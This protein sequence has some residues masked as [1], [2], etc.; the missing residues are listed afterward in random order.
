M[1]RIQILLQQI[2]TAVYGKDVRQSIHDSIEQCYTDVTSAKT[3]A[4]DSIT[5]MI[6]KIAQCDT[7]SANANEKANLA[8]TAASNADAKA[9]LAQSAAD[10]ADASATNCDNAVAELPDRVTQVFAGLGLAMI[11]GKLCVEV[12]RE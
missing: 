7:A 9:A 4:D 8:D 10:T 5:Q 6:Q 11:D 1:S 12:E 3:L 2:Q